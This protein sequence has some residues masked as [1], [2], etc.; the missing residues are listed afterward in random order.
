MSDR[1]TEADIAKWREDSERRLRNVRHDLDPHDL[2]REG[3]IAILEH[4]SGWWVGYK[5]ANGY[6][7]S[8]ISIGE[9]YCFG[10]GARW[11]IMPRDH[12]GSIVF[13]GPISD[14]TDR[15]SDARMALRLK[16]I[17]QLPPEVE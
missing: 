4:F 3:R 2:P 7:A 12:W 6:G 8:I 16:E 9:E 5:F 13:D 15:G 11:E 17:S 14:Y 10:S 1:A